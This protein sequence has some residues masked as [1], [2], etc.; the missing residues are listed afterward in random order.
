MAKKKLTPYQ[1]E[2]R[3]LQNRIKNLEKQGYVFYDI[4][5]P[6]S[7]SKVKQL[8]G[9][10]LKK[11]ATLAQQT[12]STDRSHLSGTHIDGVPDNNV[13]I[14]WEIRQRIDDTFER[15]KQVEDFNDVF[16]PFKFG[17]YRRRVLHLNGTFGAIH[18]ENVLQAFDEIIS[19]KEST[20]L[21]D[22]SAY[23]ESQQERLVELI[24]WN[25]DKVKYTEEV[26]SKVT[27]ILSILNQGDTSSF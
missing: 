7:T 12:D 8:R 14:I 11:L 27:E 23:L 3:L 1:N 19:S 18:A 2:L 13:D 9:S 10:K 15:L 5:V 22:Y 20:E 6:R 4:K 16:Y 17:S 25:S 26:E 24:D 21:D